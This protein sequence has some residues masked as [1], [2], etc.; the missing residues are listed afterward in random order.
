MAAAG[1]L[2]VFVEAT[3]GLTD[4]VTA[5]ELLASRKATGKIVLLP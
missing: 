1:K 3:F 5:H 2:R 4:V